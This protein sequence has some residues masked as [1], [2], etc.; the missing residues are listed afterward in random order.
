MAVRVVLPLRRLYQ[1]FVPGNA[2]Y[3]DPGG[4]PESPQGNSWAYWRPIYRYT[5]ALAQRSSYLHF[6]RLTAC[7]P[8]RVLDI[9]TGTGEY[10]ETIAPDHE[11]TFT[12]IDGPSLDTARERA[13][14][15]LPP[16]RYRIEQ[17]DGVS[18]LRRHPGQDL[19]A[20]IH[21]VS[22]V[23]DPHALIEAAKDC[24]NE[25]GRIVVYI[26]RF[27]KYSGWLCNP[28][29]RALGFRMFDMRAMGDGWRHERAGLLNDCFVYRKAGGR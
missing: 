13:R 14:K 9:G 23:P 21:V 6:R 10:I 26:S 8:L 17:S 2:Q 16:G 20:M 11:Y 12:D 5:W 7:A 29:F 19:I 3:A 18:A 25:N 24:L 1:A 15:R 28:L 4:P 27:S 22:V